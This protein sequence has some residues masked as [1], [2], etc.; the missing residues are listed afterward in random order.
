MSILGLIMLSP[1]F[2]FIAIL[3]KCD[4]KGPVFFRQ[5]RIGQFG[6]SFKLFKFRT[7]AIS[8]TFD[9]SPITIGMDPRIT[10]IGLVLREYK[11]DELPQL[12]DVFLGRMSLVGPRPEVPL[13]VRH[14]PKNIRNIVLSVKPG[15]TDQAS[16][17]FRFESEIL[18]KS[19]NPHRTYVE[20]II[21]IKL[22]Y[23]LEYIH[24]RSFFG[25]LLIIL[26]T[27]KVI[28]H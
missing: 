4:S 3:I 13:Y 2:L 10:R 18:A 21:P 28:A 9:I 25:D 16:I 6:K 8:D 27:L 19:S 20:K 22:N 1:I 7:M 14:Y 5:I 23:Y 26:K 12:I 15:I 17:E 11:I 24:S